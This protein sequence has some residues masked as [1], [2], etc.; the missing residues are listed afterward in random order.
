MRSPNK[1]VEIHCRFERGKG[2]WL[3]VQDQGK[4]FDADTLPDALSP[5]SLQ[6][7]HGRGIQLMKLM[8]DDVSFQRG[9][10]EVHVR[11]GLTRKSRT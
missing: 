4:G 7:E 9:G 5:E 2:V 3:I 10:T 6:A 1:L 8:M 11:K